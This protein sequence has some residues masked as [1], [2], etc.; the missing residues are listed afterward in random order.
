MTEK[1]RELL[2]AWLLSED[3]RRDSEIKE[4]Q[5]RLRYRRID[6]DFEG[7]QYRLGV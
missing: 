5:Q 3:F 6:T 4:L 2:K 7:Y 1:E